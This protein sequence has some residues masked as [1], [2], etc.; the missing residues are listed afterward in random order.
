MNSMVTVFNQ[1]THN[2]L[3][4]C[5]CYDE[6]LSNHYE[7]FRIFYEFIKNISQIKSCELIKKETD[8]CSIYVITGEQSVITKI[9]KKIEK[10]LECCNYIFIDNFDINIDVND[11]ELNISIYLKEKISKEVD[12]YENR[13][14]T[15]QGIYSGE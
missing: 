11:N 1:L 8:R 9:K 13:V 10:E 5:Q 3:T 6:V 15:Y 12:I 14:N 4:D 2:E 7:K